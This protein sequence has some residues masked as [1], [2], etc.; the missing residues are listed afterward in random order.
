MTVE[1]EPTALPHRLTDGLVTLRS[2]AATDAEALVAGYDDQARQYL[3]D[4]PHPD[5]WACIVVD[6]LV[7]GWIDYDFGRRWLGPTEANVGFLVFARHR[8]RGL[9]NRALTMLVNDH[10]VDTACTRATMLIEPENGPSLRVAE[11]SEFVEEALID[12][13]RFFAYP[14]I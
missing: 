6:G 11:R 2:P 1:L 14:T 13:E 5:P 3:G 9:A 10:L 4:S 12:G 7:A 8:G